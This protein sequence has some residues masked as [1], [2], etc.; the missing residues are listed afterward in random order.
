MTAAPYRDDLGYLADELRRLDLRIGRRLARTDERHEAMTADQVAR[1]MYVTRAE[2]DWLLAEATR[3][4]L[5]SAGP[6]G[7][8]GELERL[9][10]EIDLRRRASERAGIGL[11]LPRLGRRFGLSPL[12]LDAVVVCLA[13]ELRRA[14][15]RLYAYLQDDITR[16]R[17]SVDL[18]LDLLCATERERWAA[19]ATFGPQAPLL[20]AGILRAADD[21][22][23]PSGSSGLARFL[24]LEP[25]ITQFLLGSAALDERL[26]DYARLEMPGDASEADPALTDRVVELAGDPAPAHRRERQAAGVVDRGGASGH[27]VVYLRGRHPADIRQV[28]ASAGHRL[29]R[30]LLTVDIGA[31]G[32]EADPPLLLR[33]ALR[34]GRLHDA[35]VHVAGVDLL[36]GEEHRPTAAALASAV[37]E[38]GRTVFLSGEGEWPAGRLL[39]DDPVPEVAVPS[40]DTGRSATIWR[41]HLDAYTPH[42]A[43]WAAELAGRYRLPAARI[44]AVVRL[45][46]RERA[47][48]PQL[49]DLRAACRQQSA[50]VLGD[51]AVK[52]YPRADW[53][54]LVLPGDSVRHLREIG[55][56]FRHRARVWDDWGFGRRSGRGRGLGVLFNGPPGTGKTMAAEVLAGDLGLDLYQVD[57]AGV[58]SKYIGETEKNLAR[59]FA[60]ARTGSAILFF[61]E[62]D[63]LFGK[64]TEVSDAHDRYANIETSFL[65]QKME[66]YD[67]MVVLATNLADNLDEAFT[68]RLRF[69]VDF[70]FPDA[71]SRARIW[72]R[73]I[74]DGA[75]LSDRVDFEAL[76][77]RFPVA[78]ANIR[79]IALS[80]AFR[81]AGDGG[82][83]TEEHILHGG[84]R[85]YDKM[86][87]LWTGAAR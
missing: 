63:A 73:V 45:A 11:G 84:R 9:S 10:A 18:V 75:P 55:D 21:P 52:V 23:S 27:A 44:P 80:A 15:D 81:A 62:A 20:R 34:D 22:Q 66:E 65:L 12:E 51:L 32:P 26:T 61:D 79:N 41:A 74:P 43:A 70:P 60:E 8:V 39:L 24:A 25:H 78:G 4:P 48:A 77:Q 83:I 17:P 36:R 33:L 86:G 57:L 59:I 49:A 6:I 69:Q 38:H 3:T 72:R 13:P 46:A 5:G 82:V 14:Y 42:A 64:R 67:G 35:V 37:G 68:R 85:E 47:G 56:E 40:P 19:R 76:A 28:A 58:V 29:G 87:K 71:G 31:F 54:D 7:A 16:Q 1:A 30:P 50:P 2:V 53:D